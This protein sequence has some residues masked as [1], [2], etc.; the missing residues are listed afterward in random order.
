M[1]P[2]AFELLIERLYAAG[3]LEVW[4]TPIMMKK[5]R[6]GTV[7]SLLAPARLRAELERLILQN[8]TSFGIRVTVVD[9]TKADRAFQ[10]VATRF[11]EVPLKLK[12]VDERV[13]SATPEYDDCA[14]LARESG[15][16]FTE[17]WDEAHRIGERFVGSKITPERA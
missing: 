1:N 4:L 17:I 2:Q 10:I 16:T 9:R 12:I 3:A 6:P 15:A 5:S 11:G 14:R 7:L 8:S 13:L